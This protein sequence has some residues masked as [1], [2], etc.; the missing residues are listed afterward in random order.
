MSLGTD[1][2]FI[3]KWHRDIIWILL[4]GL[5]IFG[6]IYI[7]DKTHA[8]KIAKQEQKIASLN[9]SYAK[10]EGIKD[11]KDKVATSSLSLYQKEHEQLLKALSLRSKAP[12]SPSTTI[13]PLP[14]IQPSTTLP[15]AISELS[16]VTTDDNEAGQ[17]INKQG[18][19]IKADQDVID[20]Q[21]EII[22]GVDVENTQLK[23]DVDVQT[24]RKKIWRDS[25]LG[26][27]G[28]ILLHFLL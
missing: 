19:D 26:E 20:N 1:L 6:T 2:T 22:L 21:K 18:E 14:D 17:V 9:T 10:L 7:K 27:L 5:A 11:E 25:A 15:N 8:E 16:Q 12:I 3:E 23:K 13:I 24:K 28:L 4:A